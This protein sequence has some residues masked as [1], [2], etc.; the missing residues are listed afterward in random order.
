MHTVELSKILVALGLAKD[1]ITALEG[2]HV[3]TVILQV[4]LTNSAGRDC[5]IC[6]SDS[7]V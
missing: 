3:S 1:A 2:T 6:Q 4:L 5:R 7:A